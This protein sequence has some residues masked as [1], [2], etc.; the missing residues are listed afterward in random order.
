V[1]QPS[2]QLLL[3]GF[4]SEAEFEGRFV[5]ALERLES[6]GA[7]EIL[8]VLLVHRHSEDGGF[9]AVSIE[10]KGAGGIAGPLVEFRLEP[11][12]R[13][14]ATEKA[15]AGRMGAVPPELVRGIAAG[16]EPGAA[17]AAVLVD[18]TWQRVLEDAVDRSGGV[19]MTTE[20]VDARKLSELGPGWYVA[21]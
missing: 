5:G 14:R 4:N 18:H 15:L 9:D 13:R 2:V 21:S 16:L 6:G 11:A 1:T 17:I 8:D 10:G 20:F 19:R 12:A 3:Y 7:M